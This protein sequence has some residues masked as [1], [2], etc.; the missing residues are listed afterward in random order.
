MHNVAV[1][2]VS[3]RKKPNK[4][5]EQYVM[6]QDGSEPLEP[7]VALEPNSSLY[8]QNGTVYPCGKGAE[9]PHPAQY[10]IHNM[11][12]WHYRDGCCAH[13]MV[14]GGYCCTLR[15]ASQG[16]L[17]AESPSGQERRA[18]KR[19]RREKRGDPL[20]DRDRSRERERRRRELGGTEVGV[21]REWVSVCVCVCV[22]EQVVLQ[23][24]QYKEDCSFWCWWERSRGIVV[25]H[26]NINPKCLSLVNGSVCLGEHGYGITTVSVRLHFNSQ[27]RLNTFFE[28]YGV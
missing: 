22:G 1:D 24:K 28:G 27:H 4:T 7:A 16:C 10:R 15:A 26:R 18:M 12:P 23:W 2:A 3:L 19:R 13:M 6:G 9:F 21:V 14:F 17:H 20:S 8:D 11:K 25:R 5:S